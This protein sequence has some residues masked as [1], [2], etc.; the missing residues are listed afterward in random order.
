M[1]WTRIFLIVTVGALV[2]M[3]MGGLF[4]VAAGYIAPNLFR[5]IVPWADLEP[6]GVATVLGAVAGVLLGGGLAVFA[7]VLQ[8]LLKVRGKQD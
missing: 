3:L 8:A 5:Q 6:R 4:G 2:G 7:V 1:T